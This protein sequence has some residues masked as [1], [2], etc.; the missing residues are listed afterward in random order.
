MISHEINSLVSAKHGFREFEQVFRVA[1]I[2]KPFEEPVELSG[3]L[4]MKRDVIGQIYRKE[5]AEL[6]TK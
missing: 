1:L 3:T 6:F 2:S 5:I 4:K